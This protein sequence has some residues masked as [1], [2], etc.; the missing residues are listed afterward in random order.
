[1]AVTWEVSDT[2]GLGSNYQSCVENEANGHGYG[3]LYYAKRLSNSG[4]LHR[5]TVRTKKW[6]GL[7]KYEFQVYTHY[8][9]IYDTE[10]GSGFSPDVT[11][12]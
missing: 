12:L 4:G 6:L 1:M 7:Q 3:S 10:A 2:S 11:Q 8:D 9:S 5:F